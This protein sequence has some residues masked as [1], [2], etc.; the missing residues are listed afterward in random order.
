MRI[1]Y[2]EKGSLIEEAGIN[3]RVF[4]GF[5]WF[6]GGL[7]LDSFAFAVALSAGLSVEVFSFHELI[8][9]LENLPFSKY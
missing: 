2:F 7:A 5:N 4:L 9:L 6:I 3:A 1:H 8:L